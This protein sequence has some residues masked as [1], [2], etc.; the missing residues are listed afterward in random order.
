MR[1]KIKT[2]VDLIRHAVSG[3]PKAALES[4]PEIALESEQRL[5]PPKTPALHTSKLIDNGAECT[6]CMRTETHSLVIDQFIWELK[7]VYDIVSI[8][9]T[10]LVKVIDIRSYYDIG[11]QL[12]LFSERHIDH[13]DLAKPI[14][15]GWM[16]W[17]NNDKLMIIDGWHRVAKAYREGRKQLFGYT[18][19]MYE[20]SLCSVGGK[21]ACGVD[22]RPDTIEALIKITPNANTYINIV[23]ESFN[24][25]VTQLEERQQQLLDDARK[26]IGKDNW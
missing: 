17:G 13:V 11:T 14:V 21:L 6:R 19:S 2:A 5:S 16:H 23:K 7:S 10:N 3:P 24:D 1:N 22:N 9:R 25:R 4:Q 15:L 12:N 8:N 20:S 26:H 18:L